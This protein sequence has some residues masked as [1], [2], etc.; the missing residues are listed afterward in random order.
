ME[1]QKFSTATTRTRPL[2]SLVA[3][4]AVAQPVAR[5]SETAAATA[6]RSQVTPPS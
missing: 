5:S 4:T 6:R 2:W 1:P 3:D